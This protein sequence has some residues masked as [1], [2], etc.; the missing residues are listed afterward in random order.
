M[1]ELELEQS[2]VC[3]SYRKRELSQL[4]FPYNAQATAIKK[5][6]DMMRFSPAV[7]QR[8]QLA[9]INRC[10]RYYTSLQVQLIVDCFGE[11]G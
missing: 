6:N 3:K 5:F 4:Y 1:E 2:F 7:E 9:G 11:P 10:T 8:L